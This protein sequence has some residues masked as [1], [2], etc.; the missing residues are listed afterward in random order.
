VVD[1]VKE[2]ADVPSSL[3]ISKEIFRFV[4]RHETSGGGVLFKNSAGIFSPA[5]S[6]FSAVRTRKVFREAEGDAA[7]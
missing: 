7:G 4:D 2:F 6:G 1:P 5:W 3:S